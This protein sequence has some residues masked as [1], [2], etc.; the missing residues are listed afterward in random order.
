MKRV[1]LVLSLIFMVSLPMFAQDDL[2]NERIN[3]RKGNELYEK[4]DYASAEVAYRKALEANPSSDIAAFNLATALLLQNT[5]DNMQGSADG[6]QEVSTADEATNI[7]KGLANRAS[8]DSVPMLL[9]QVNYNLG[10]IA[11]N[12]ENYDESIAYY[13]KTLRINPTDEDARKNLR[14]AQLK[15]QEQEENQDEDQ[16]DQQD[17]DQNQ[18]QQD[19]NQDQQEQNQDQDQQE[20]E[21]EQKDEQNQQ[22]NNKE[23]EQQ[24]EQQQQQ[25][26]SYE[27]IDQILKTLQDQ[28][29]D[30]QQKVNAKKMEEQENSRREINNQW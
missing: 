26:M 23:Q 4:D 28:E 29:R 21:Q 18:D 5:G 2:R 3:I 19:Q 25:Q 27:N 24:Q 10:N 20:Q 12:K 14:L 7:L 16:Q 30:T 9:S 1:I 22:N 6:K 8:M 11:F 17:Q 15:K 13:K